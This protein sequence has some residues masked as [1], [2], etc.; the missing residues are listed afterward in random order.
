MTDTFLIAMNK[1]P[2]K[3]YSSLA[4]M[5]NACDVA[6]TF[7]GIRNMKQRQAWLPWTTEPIVPEV[8]FRHSTV[9]TGKVQYVRGYLEASPTQA[10]GL[11][12][13]ILEGVVSQRK[14]GM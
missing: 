6:G 13:G 12:E 3:I 10:W 7:L 8:G 9:M 2:Q 5:V 4:C 11:R 1:H 14:L